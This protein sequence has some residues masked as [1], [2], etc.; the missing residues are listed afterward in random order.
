MIFVYLIIYELSE[1][2]LSGVKNRT[3]VK[4]EDP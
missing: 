1:F 4:L 3:I 2:H